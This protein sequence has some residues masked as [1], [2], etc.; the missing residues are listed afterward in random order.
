MVHGD[1]KPKRGIEKSFSLRGVKEA[2]KKCAPKSGAIDNVLD[3]INQAVE[4]DNDS[5]CAIKAVNPQ[6]KVDLMKK[7]HALYKSAALR[8]QKENECYK[9]EAQ[10]LS[11]EHQ[12]MAMQLQLLQKMYQEVCREH[13][14]T[15]TKL[16]AYRRFIE[17]L[18]R[19]DGASAIS[20]FSDRSRK[21]TPK[22][23]FS[24]SKSINSVNSSSSS[25]AFTSSQLKVTQVE[26][27]CDTSDN[28]DI[29]R[30]LMN[31]SQGPSAKTRKVEQLSMQSGGEESSQQ[32]DRSTYEVIR[33]V[34]ATE[35]DD[36]DSLDRLSEALVSN[37]TGDSTQD[38]I[39]RQDFLSTAPTH[40]SS[41]YSATS[42]TRPEPIH[43]NVLPWLCPSSLQ[44]HWQQQ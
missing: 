17:S 43:A 3:D 42:L 27:C 23:E 39:S 9:R 35:N 20:D 44:Q 7:E 28:S 22:K 21:F 24:E 11:Y 40:G 41:N 14:H 18:P 31:Q 15:Q 10:R 38:R 6:Y 12:V 32:P 19:E 25:S 8:L 1:S 36:D 37:L 33:R 5:C 13:H 26:Q 30:D 29:R 16:R 2:L 34:R 4:D